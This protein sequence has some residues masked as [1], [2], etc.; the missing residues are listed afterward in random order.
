MHPEARALDL[1]NEHDPSMASRLASQKAT[2][3][4]TGEETNGLEA[5]LKQKAIDFRLAVNGM[6]KR[7]VENGMNP[8]Q[9]EIAASELAVRDVLDPS[10]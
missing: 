4:E 3:P 10:T 8:G 9:A 2:D 1:M 6:I 5:Y 7:F